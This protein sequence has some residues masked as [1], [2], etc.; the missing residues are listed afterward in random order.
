MRVVFAER[1]K[2]GGLDLEAVEMTLRTALHQAGAAGLSELLRQ[3]SPAPPTLSC[4]CGDQARYKG[5]RPKSLVT[6]LGP[7]EMLRAY[8]W[9]SRCRQGQFSTDAALDIEDTGFSPGVRRMLAL[10]G[11]ECSSFDRGRE[12]MDLL[13]GLEVTAKAVERVTESIGADIARREQETMR[14]VMQL[15]LPLVVG[16]PIPVIYVQ[17]DATGVPVV[18]Q[19]TEGRTGKGEDGKAHTR[20]V[21]LGCIFTQT[22][23]DAEGWPVR[24]EQSTTYTGAIETAGEFSRRIY[25]EAFQRGWSRAEKK[26]VMGDG[27]EWIWNLRQEQFPGAI[28]IVDLYH[29]RQHLWDLGTKLH[30]SDEA[31]KR[32]WVMA[33]QHLLED[34]KIEQLVAKLRVLPCDDPKLAESIQK[35]ANYFEGNAARMRYPE[36]RR[37]G[38]FVGTGVIEAGCKTVIGSRLKRSGMFW[39]VRGADAVIALRCCRQ[40]REFDDYWESRRA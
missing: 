34:G 4:P 24:E 18:P 21:K 22:T 33:R 37:Q 14:Q 36:F 30:P 19:E 6:V 32:R 39:T 8:Y 20:E 15:K 16:R 28:E 17:M 11:S 2:T 1:R 3:P 10:V 23:T 5:M 9:C 38:L 29:A 12:Q 35:E 40:S 7:A 31:L 25:T 27:A 13:A 26:V